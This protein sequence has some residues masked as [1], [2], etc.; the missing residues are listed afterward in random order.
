M[1]GTSGAFY[2]HL[3]H[4]VLIEARG[5]NQHTIRIPSTA[6]L[7]SGCS[8]H[9]IYQ[10]LSKSF[11]HI[12]RDMFGIKECLCCPPCH[13]NP[14]G[15][16]VSDLKSS[17]GIHFRST[18]ERTEVKDGSIDRVHDLDISLVNGL[19]QFPPR[20]DSYEIGLI[21]NRGY[22]LEPIILQYILHDSKNAFGVSQK[23]HGTG[24]I[25]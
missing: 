17:P 10:N 3:N 8:L 12:L 14:E 6:R 23:D 16:A 24:E 11:F 2:R 7:Y 4:E 22:T 5:M 1:Y 9:I 20:S 25:N 13:G 19:I 15:S 18:S 21:I